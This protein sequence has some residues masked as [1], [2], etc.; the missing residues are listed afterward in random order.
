MVSVPAPVMP[1]LIESHSHL[2]ADLGSL[3]HRAWLS[4]GITTVRSPGGTPYEAAS[5]REMAMATSS[6][7]RAANQPRTRR[8][9]ASAR[10]RIL[11]EKLVQS[12]YR[13]VELEH[14]LE[15]LRAGTSDGSPA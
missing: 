2:Q 13:I 4:W 12:E 9:S 14:E 1:G 11:A 8:S 3:D 6:A 7:R 10:C 5:D 15:R